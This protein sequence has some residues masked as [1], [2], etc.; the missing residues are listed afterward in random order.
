VSAAAAAQFAEKAG[1]GAGGRNAKLQSKGQNSDNEC[2][3]QA[4]QR[5]HLSNPRVMTAH[6]KWAVNQATAKNAPF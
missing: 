4:C 2:R 5:H 1:A 3:F 6:G